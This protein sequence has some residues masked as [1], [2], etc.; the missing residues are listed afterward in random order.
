MKTNDWDRVI[1][2]KNTDFFAVPFAPEPAGRSPFGLAAGE[3][4]G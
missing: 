2:S 1:S 3:T 4:P